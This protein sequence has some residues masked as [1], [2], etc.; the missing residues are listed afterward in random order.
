LTA[1]GQIIDYN[2]DIQVC[3]NGPYQQ[4][5][6]LEIIEE[7]I[8]THDFDGI[9]FN[10]GGFQTRNYSGDYFGPCHCEHCQQAF[11]DMFGLSLP[12]KEDMA[13]P[14]YRHYTVFK[15]RVIEAHHRKVYDFI[16]NLRPDI[17][18]ANH[19]E[20]RAG[21]VR[22]E[23]NT[24][25]DR[26]LPHWQYSASDNTKWV[27]G[28]YPQMVCTNTT[29]DFI[30]F[31]YRHVA[32]SPQQQRLRLAQNTA[33]GGAVDF[34]LIGRLDNHE[35]RSGYAPV[36]ELFH[37]RA[38]HEEDYRDIHSLAKIALLNGPG[39]NQ[40]EFRGWFRF[41]T[42][43]H[44]PFDTRLVDTA[45][46]LPWDQ[47]QAI[48]MPDL[49]PISDALA[50]MIDNFVEAGGVLIAAGR[51]GFWD[52]QYE[53]RALPAFRSLGIEQVEQIR[54]EMRSSYFKLNDKRDF[55]R[56]DA[57]DLLYLDSPYIHAQYAP[58]AELHLQLIP[59][60]MFGP[61]ERCYYTQTTDHPGL[62]IH[63]YGQGRA[64]YLPWLPGSLFQRQG[65]VNTTDFVAD[66][67][68]N[69]AGLTAVNGNLS[70]M[71]EV[72][73]FAKADGSYELLHLVNGSGHFGVSFFAPVTMTN[74]EVVIPCDQEPQ[75]VQ[76][77]VSGQNFG[78]QSQPGQL[79]IQVPRLELMEA[80]KINF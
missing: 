59:P 52:E 77:L 67:L 80:I 75:S 63:P 43:N 30:D 3:I 65:Y 28:S 10:M 37:Y 64:I 42:E 4:E 13:D 45:L 35:D 36:K 21:F 12:V 47:Y 5:Y 27:V 23:S 50:D 58:E 49:Q 32:V 17:A 66:L 46:E 61:P 70:P 6:A 55:P 9:F 79:T 51:S 14:V 69:V 26:A 39:A 53:P 68:E 60:H 7:I 56:F 11:A 15:E 72:T 41:L 31:P 1:D 20:M 74:L 71:V 34:Y 40:Q 19:R 76:G 22:Q 18:I 24:A 73:R 2:G 8:T 25:I 38:A 16:T 29:V 54:T 62:I 48:I 44:F 57:V 33:N 78:Y